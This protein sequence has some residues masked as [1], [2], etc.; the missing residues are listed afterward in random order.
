MKKSCVMLFSSRAS[1]MSRAIA[2]VGEAAGG[3]GWDCLVVIFWLVADWMPSQ[4]TICS[5]LGAAGDRP[6]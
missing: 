3:K 5:A 2:S 6:L 4:L 1:V